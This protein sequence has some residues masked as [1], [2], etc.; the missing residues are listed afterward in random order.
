VIALVTCRAARDLD[1]DLPLLERELPEGMVVSW[2]D[3]TV[4][5]AAFGVVILRSAWD[6]HQRRDEFLTWARHVAQ[7]SMLWN[8]IEVI[9]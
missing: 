4:D 9:E 2:D 6:Y 3:D 7:V 5:W 1:T 8:P